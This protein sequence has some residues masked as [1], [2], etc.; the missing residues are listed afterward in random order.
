MKVATR[1]AV[2]VNGNTI[3]LLSHEGN[4]SS[5][6]C[7]PAGSF[8]AQLEMTKNDCFSSTLTVMATS[9]VNEAFIECSL[10]GSSQSRNGSLRVV[11]KVFYT[12]MCLKVISVNT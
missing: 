11:G 3:C 12:C 6:D 5:A 1:W 2:N 10:L 4:S 8:R 9:E 7:G